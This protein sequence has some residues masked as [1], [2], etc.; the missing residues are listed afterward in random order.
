MSTEADRKAN[1][2]SHV[3]GDGNVI[4][5]GVGGKLELIEQNCGR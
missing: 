2:R 3:A 5:T 1:L 4:E